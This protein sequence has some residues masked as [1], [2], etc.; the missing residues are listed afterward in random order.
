VISAA[1]AQRL[2][3]RLAEVERGT[4]HQFVVALFQ[5]LD[6]ESLD[7]YTNRLFRFWKIGAAKANDGVLFALYQSDRRW[8]VEVGYG[9]E[10]ILTDLEAAEMA[11]A[12]VPSFQA[13]DYAGGVGAVTAAIAARL[14][15]GA[16]PN[17]RANPSAAQ[18]WDLAKTLVLLFV[19]FL[20]IATPFGRLILFTMITSGGSSGGG[21]SGGGGGFS[22]GGGSS[23]GGGASG[24][25]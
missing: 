24:G 6:G 20:L 9:L 5:S 15:S 8:R 10:P 7:D 12:G 4:G 18:D 25:W 19:L 13:G 11:R 17:R 3:A 14:E 21:G 2:G 1:D 16:P 22:G 23:G